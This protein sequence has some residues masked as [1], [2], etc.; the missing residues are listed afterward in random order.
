MFVHVVAQ[1][2]LPLRVRADGLV[3]IHLDFPDQGGH[4]PFR[5]IGRNVWKDQSTSRVADGAGL[6]A[7]EAVVGVDAEAQDGGDFHGLVAA[8]GG[9]K[10]PA[11]QSG[12]NFRGHVGGSGFEDAY[13]L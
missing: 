1:L 13:V 2:A 3:K 11:A 7:L 12:E 9:L 5:A 8:H 6:L 10:L 4:R